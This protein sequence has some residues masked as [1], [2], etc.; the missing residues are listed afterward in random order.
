MKICVMSGAVN[1]AGDYL[2]TERCEKLI[3]SIYP[4]TEIVRVIR[5]YP[6]VSQLDLINE[7]DCI[8]FAGGPGYRDDVYPNVFPLVENLE[9]IC[10]PMAYIG[11]G[12]G[13]KK[14]LYMEKQIEKF[15]YAFNEQTQKFLNRIVKDT[16]VLG[17]RDWNTVRLLQA[18]GYNNVLMTGCPAWYDIKSIGVHEIADEKKQINRI[19]VS[20][21]AASEYHGEQV[22]ELLK[23]LRKR[24]PKASITYVLHKGKNKDATINVVETIN[25]RWGG[26]IKCVDISGSAEGF[27]I[28]DD[29]DFHVGFRVHAHIYNL[30]IR[31]RTILIEEDVRGSGVNNALGL[32]RIMAENEPQMSAGCKWGK[33]KRRPEKLLNEKLILQ[34]D[35]Y[36]NNILYSDDAIFTAAFQNIDSY[37][38]VMKKHIRL[39]VENV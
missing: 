24:F 32:W 6:I 14:S 31:N 16:G 37:Y 18:N 30:S 4:D 1:N 7:C 21:S 8:I 33:K 39:I 15:P 36:L 5:N 28:Y 25:R 17:C 2:I 20:D 26:D 19:C 27:K 12:C 34:I 10:P 11:G 29:C 13:V 38:E 22:L 3:Q 23:Y 9:D 35:S